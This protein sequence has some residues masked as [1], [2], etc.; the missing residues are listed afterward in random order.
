VEEVALHAVKSKDRP[1]RYF[2]DVTDY[3]DGDWR[4]FDQAFDIAGGKFHALVARHHAHCTLLCGYEEHLEIELTRDYL[5]THA[6]DGL[7][8]RLYGPGSV[9]SAPFLVPAGYLRGF[10]RASADHGLFAR[11]AAQP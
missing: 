7:L 6:S 5:E 4:G 2:L 9:A 11:P 8:M 3:Y 1:A 10:L